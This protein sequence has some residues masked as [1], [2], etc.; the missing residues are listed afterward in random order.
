MP[1]LNW[2]LIIPV[3]CIIAAVGIFWGKEGVGYGLFVTGLILFLGHW[4]SGD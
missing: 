3:G 1:R 2:N 4:L